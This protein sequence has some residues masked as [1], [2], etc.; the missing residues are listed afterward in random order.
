MFHSVRAGIAGMLSG[1]GERLAPADPR[2]EYVMEAWDG[3]AFLNDENKTQKPPI[4]GIV[5]RADD[6]GEYVQVPRPAPADLAPYSPPE[7]Q[8]RYLAELEAALTDPDLRGRL[9]ADGSLVMRIRI[10]PEMVGAID[11][12]QERFGLASRAQV[13]QKGLEL[14]KLLSTRRTYNEIGRELISEIEE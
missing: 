2:D 4:P 14:I 7:D 10:E 9:E 12:A 5:I 11:R 1:L 6:L 8:P 3:W 13:L